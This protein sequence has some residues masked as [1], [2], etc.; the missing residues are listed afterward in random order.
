MKYAIIVSKKDLAG[1]NIKNHLIELG[2]KETDEKLQNNPIY[3]KETT[4]LYTL[5]IET[6]NSENID[7]LIPEQIIIFATRHQSAKEIPSLSLHCQGNFDKATYGGKNHTIGI[8]PA[9]IMK[10]F[11]QIL[12]KNNNSKHEV[13]LE[14]THHGP[15]L[16]KPSF[17]IE[18]GSNKNHWQNKQLGK[19]LAE[20][21]IEAINTKIKTYKTAIGIGG[22]HYAPNFTKIQ[23]AN[24]YAIGHIIPTYALEFLDKDMLNQLIEKTVPTPKTIILD[25]KGLKSHKQEIKKLLENKKVIRC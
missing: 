14:V 24:D 2:F 6:I 21:I 8:A 19:I 17:F 13:T 18:I 20:T 15:D 7:K 5:N 1:I 22:P 4:K 16:N 3:K 9:N 23:L 25:Y 11:F 12:N 10:H